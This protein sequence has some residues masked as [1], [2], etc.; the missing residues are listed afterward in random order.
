LPPPPGNDLLAQVLSS[1][2]SGFFSSIIFDR[3]RVC[4]QLRNPSEYFFQEEGGLIRTFGV[5]Y[6]EIKF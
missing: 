4:G 2:D 6:G 3:I 1:L 5:K